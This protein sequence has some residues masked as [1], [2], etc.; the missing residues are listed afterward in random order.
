MHNVPYWRKRL[1]CHFKTHLDHKLLLAPA[2]ALWW[3]TKLS[4]HAWL[5]Q[6]PWDNIWVQHLLLRGPNVLQKS[7]HYCLFPVQQ[8]PDPCMQLAGALQQATVGLCFNIGLVDPYPSG[9]EK[10]TENMIFNSFFIS[11]MQARLSAFKTWLCNNF[12]CFFFFSFCFFL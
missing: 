1:C 7:K 4:P 8:D 2:P 5:Q 12:F 6:E 9:R 11:G 3:S 10:A